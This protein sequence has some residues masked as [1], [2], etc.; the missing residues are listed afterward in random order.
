MRPVFLR[1]CLHAVMSHL[2][3]LEIH[4]PD[5]VGAHPGQ[6]D[7]ALHDLK[8]AGPEA[9]RVPRATQ[10]CGVEGTESEGPSITRLPNVSAISV[11]P[12]GRRSA[13]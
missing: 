4:D 5:F 1:A 11:L 9:C 3:G 10:A 2:V 8:I 6:V 7:D 13:S 12:F